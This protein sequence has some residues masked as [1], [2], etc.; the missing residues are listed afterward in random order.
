MGDYLYLFNLLSR[1][2]MCRAGMAGPIPISHGCVND[3]CNGVGVNLYPTER[4]IIVATSQ[5]YVSWLNK[6]VN[7]GEN[8]P[9]AYLSDGSI[10]HEYLG[11][12]AMAL[13]S[14]RKRSD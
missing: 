5:S 4:E 9:M 1:I 13:R 6:G 8:S 10:D 7:P 3:W 12:V 14:T 2:G 11:R